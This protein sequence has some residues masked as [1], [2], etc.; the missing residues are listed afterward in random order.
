[1]S[2]LKR[3]LPTE[4]NIARRLILSEIL[5]QPVAVRLMQ[6]YAQ[7]QMQIKAS[8]TSQPANLHNSLSPSA[9]DRS[10]DQLN[11]QVTKSSSDG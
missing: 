7:K 1:M 5:G 11:R 4:D 10:D 9:V 2:I 3:L 6:Q 8:Q